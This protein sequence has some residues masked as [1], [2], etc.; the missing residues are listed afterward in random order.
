[1]KFIQLI[2]GINSSIATYACPWCKVNKEDRGNVTLPWDFYHSEKFF[3]SIS[4][5]KNLARSSSKTYGVK[6][7]PLLDVEP[8][9]YIPDELHLLMRIM[10]VLLRN[11][12]YDASPKDDYGKI[13]GNHTD[14]VNLLV[15]A[16]Q[17]CGVPFTI[18]LSKSG[19]KEWTSLT[20]NSL[21]KLLYGLHQK[22]LFCLHE[23]TADDV[24]KLWG[25]F[26]DIYETIS[27]K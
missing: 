26:K 12:I 18:W 7:A 21:K 23:D 2:L 4:V 1:M 24:I 5:I 9:H 25:D 27:D 8:H 10:D 22:L 20:G 14:N 15:K 16:V 6:A 11:L 19:E 17:S 13:V 3:R